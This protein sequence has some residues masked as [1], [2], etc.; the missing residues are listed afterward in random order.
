MMS[1]LFRQSPNAVHEIQRLLKVGEAELTMNVMFICDRP[2][3]NVLVELRQVLPR[4]RGNSA[5]AGH[6]LFVGKLFSHEVTPD[7]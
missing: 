3:G 1:L 7:L 6:T 5:A 2:L 4:E